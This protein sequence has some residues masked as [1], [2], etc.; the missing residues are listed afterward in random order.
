MTQRC[1]S[2]VGKSASCETSHKGYIEAGDSSILVFNHS[3]ILAW[4]V[5]H[6]KMPKMLGM[7]LIMYGAFCLTTFLASLTPNFNYSKLVFMHNK[8]R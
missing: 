8:L 7:P 4:P 2:N 3:S 1:D 6:A 5:G